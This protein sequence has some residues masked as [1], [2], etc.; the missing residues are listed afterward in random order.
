MGGLC[1]LIPSCSTFFLVIANEILGA[2]DGA[3]SRTVMT[4]VSHG[5]DLRYRRGW[6]INARGGPS[7]IDSHG[8]YPS[9]LLG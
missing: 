7:E 5:Q 4:T 6:M 9:L 8:K 3:I 2:T 1:H